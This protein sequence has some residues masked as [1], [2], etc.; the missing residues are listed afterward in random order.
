MTATMAARYP[1]FV[2][3]PVDKLI[4]CKEDW[5]VQPILTTIYKFFAP[6]LLYPNGTTAHPPDRETNN[7]D[8]P[9]NEHAAET[10]EKDVR[11]PYLI[12]FLTIG[13]ADLIRKPW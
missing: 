11:F 8:C 4:L 1:K 2:A 12:C 5:P 13:M 3:R 7:F 6:R 9:F 10:S